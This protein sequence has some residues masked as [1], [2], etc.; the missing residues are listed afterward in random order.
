MDAVVLAAGK[1]SRMGEGVS[2]Q[3]TRIGGKPMMV[4]SIERLLEHEEID[5]IIVTCP[6]S[7]LEQIRGML[8]DF[9]LDNNCVVI[10][11][12]ATRQESVAL[13]LENV[14][15]ERVL[16]HEAARPLIT[17]KLLDRVIGHGGPATVPVTE[18]PFTVAVGADTMESDLNRSTLRNVQLPQVFDTAVLRSAHENARTNGLQS[19]EDS[20]LVFWLGQPVAFVE[21]SESN[22]K[23]TYPVDL[24][25]AEALVYGE[26]DAIG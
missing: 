15:T 7:L 22:L 5:R 12:G 9:R 24:L 16:I 18:V 20:Q 10:A 13:A 8:G 19:T 25:V 3:L 21:G 4:F 14:Q 2:K 6:Q 17:E 23:V 26:K 1:S 11:G